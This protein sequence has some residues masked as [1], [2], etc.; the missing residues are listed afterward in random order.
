MFH[1][2]LEVPKLS[3]IIPTYNRYA[4]VSKCLEYLARQTLPNT[5]YEVI[6][7]DDGSE[8]TLS[9][10]PVPV[11]LK[12]IRIAHQ[13]GAT[14]RN[15][16]L[17]AASSPVLLFLDDDV[18]L[19]PKILEE[20]LLAHLNDTGI[21]VIQGCVTW[22]LGLE[23]TLFMKWLENGGPQYSFN[24]IPFHSPAY[25]YFYTCH[26]SIKREVFERTGMLDSGLI[27]GVYD[28]LEFGYRFFQAGFK[29]VFRPDLIGAHHRPVLSIR[30][31]CDERMVTLG[32]SYPLY[33][34]KVPPEAKRLEQV[35]ENLITIGGLDEKKYAYK[36]EEI[37]SQVLVEEKTTE[38]LTEVLCNL[39]DALTDLSWKYGI[40]QSL[41]Q[42]GLRI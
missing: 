15:V 42:E 33:A 13:G 29:Y 28:D 5:D 34:R 22:D 26:I 4:I 40:W 39:Y 3:V 9:F 27:Y 17:L 32:R 7:V 16:G 23:I 14:A 36:Q 20:H 1:G 25:Y 21:H 37:L 31:Y 19:P 11:D 6:V 30:K 8:K 18:W 41:Y 38:V 2:E 35:K 10:S 12:V 24:E